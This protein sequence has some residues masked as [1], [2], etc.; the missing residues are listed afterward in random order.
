MNTVIAVEI[1]SI[2]LPFATLFS[3]PVW[4]Q[5]LFLLVGAILTTGKRTM[6]SVLTG[7]GL[8]EEEH[9]QNY[10]RV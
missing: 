6:T 5:A 3:K 1:A 4:S 8:S 2:V 9:F 7:M 10:H